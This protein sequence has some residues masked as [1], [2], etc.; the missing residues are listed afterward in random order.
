MIN[1]VGIH[2]LLKDNNKVQVRQF[3]ALL[4]EHDV[5]LS[6][7]TI[8]DF[9]LAENISGYI[10]KMFEKNFIIEIIEKHGNEIDSKNEKLQSSSRDGLKSYEGTLKQTDGEIHSIPK[11]SYI[12]SGTKIIKKTDLSHYVI[13]SEDT[14]YDNFEGLF[15][16][17][18]YIEPIILNQT[19]CTN[20]IY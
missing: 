3:P 7:I 9:L 13:K 14:N 18:E 6:F 8:I 20:S 15:K 10:E 19:L 16:H 5:S 17:L 4:R 1:Q 12:A 11:T 2:F